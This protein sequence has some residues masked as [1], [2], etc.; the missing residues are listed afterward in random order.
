MSD[1]GKTKRESTFEYYTNDPTLFIGS[2]T[3]VDFL[4]DSGLLILISYVL[5]Y[6]IEVLVQI[7]D[8]EGA[9]GYRRTFTDHLVNN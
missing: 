8:G 3:V 9:F 7:V 5:S 1:D 2:R 6:F 4:K